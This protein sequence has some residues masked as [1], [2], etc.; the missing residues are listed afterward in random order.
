MTVSSSDLD[1]FFWGWKDFE[2]DQ[3]YVGGGGGARGGRSV[4]FKAESAAL[5]ELRVKYKR[6]DGYT[7][8][9]WTG[10]LEILTGKK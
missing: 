3:F 7:Q 8:Y 2:L 9:S 1:P 4:K 6:N 5:V 10:Q